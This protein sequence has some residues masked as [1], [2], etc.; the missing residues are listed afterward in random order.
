MKKTIFI[1]LAVLM[2]A[3]PVFAGGGRDNSRAAADKPVEL[4]WYVGG[5]G[6]QVDLPAVLEE[7]NKYLVPKLNCTL[8]IIETDF[9]NYNQKMQ[10]VI[11]SQEEFDLCYTAD[12]SNDFYGNVSKNAYLELD[13][14]ID[15]YAP[16]LRNDMP[17]NGWTAA[18]VNGKIMAVPCQQIWARAN[19]WGVEAQ[20]LDKYNI[21]PTAVKAV[22]DMEP[23]LAAI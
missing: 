2:A 8:K 6:A 12:W 17:A 3:L 10:M 19:G 13:A 21:D 22:K 23:L 20:Y 4:I 5:R 18:K 1:L 7:V 16:Q 15:Q 11:A 9:G 14:L